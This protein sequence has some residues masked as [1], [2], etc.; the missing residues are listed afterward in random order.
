MNEGKSIKPSHPPHRHNNAQTIFPTPNPLPHPPTMLSS[1]LTAAPL[2]L[3]ASTANA[4]PSRRPDNYDPKHH[5]KNQ[6]GNDIPLD[7]AVRWQSAHA[8][9]T[10]LVSQM[11]LQEIANITQGQNETFGCGGVTGSVPRLNFPGLCLQDG[12]AGVRGAEFVNAYPAAISAA[13]SFNRELALER[14]RFM[15]GEFRAKGVDTAL[16]VCVGAIG[17]VAKGG[18]NW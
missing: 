14:G 3:L 9:A 5:H 7:P 1:F 13:A 16:S 2:L 17:R 8:A 11:T 4:I 18:R 10:A 15:G 6:Y 12:P